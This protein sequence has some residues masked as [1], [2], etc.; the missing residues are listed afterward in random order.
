MSKKKGTTHTEEI[1][2]PQRGRKRNREGCHAT[3][4]VKT[5]VLAKN[6]DEPAHQP[7][8]HRRMTTT[9]QLE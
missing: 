4:G 9:K 6:N 1:V 5:R 3:C 2:F 7:Q 8:N